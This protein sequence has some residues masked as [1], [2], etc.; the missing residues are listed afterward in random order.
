MDFNEILLWTF[1]L[2]LVEE[3]QFDLKSDKNNGHIT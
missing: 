1:L 3:I 2:K